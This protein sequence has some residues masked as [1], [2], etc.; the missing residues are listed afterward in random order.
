MRTLQTTKLLPE[1]QAGKVRWSSRPVQRPLT[2][3]KSERLA[4]RL[5]SKPHSDISLTV[6]KILQEVKSA[7]F[8]LDIGL[9]WTLTFQNEELFLRDH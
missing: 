1:K 4:P 6:S 9:M 8:G 2:K 7:R 5:N 3:V